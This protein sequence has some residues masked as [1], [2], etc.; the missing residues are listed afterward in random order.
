MDVS[1]CAAAAAVKEEREE[2]EQQDEEASG[3]EKQ[4][5]GGEEAVTV[6]VPPQDGADEPQCDKD[7][8]VEQTPVELK[9][10]EHLHIDEAALSLLDGWVGE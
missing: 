1:F 6:V 8:E 10:M 5:E 4:V 9:G 2:D 7:P 3:A